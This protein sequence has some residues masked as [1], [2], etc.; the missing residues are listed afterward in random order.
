MRLSSWKCASIVACAVV[1]VGLAAFSTTFSIFYANQGARALREQTYVY[2]TW[3]LYFSSLN[4][5]GNAQYTTGEVSFEEEDCQDSPPLPAGSPVKHGAFVN[6]SLYWSTKQNVRVA[7]HKVIETSGACCRAR[8]L[9][10][11]RCWADRVRRFWEDGKPRVELASIHA[12]KRS[13]RKAGISPLTSLKNGELRLK[14]VNGE[15]GF[16]SDAVHSRFKWK[17]FEGPVVHTTAPMVLVRCV[18]SCKGYFRRFMEFLQRQDYKW[19][20]TRLDFISFKE[21]Y[22]KEQHQ[23]IDHDLILTQSSPSPTIEKRMERILCADPSAR[24]KLSILYVWMDSTSR[25]NFVNNFPMT[26]K[27]LREAAT[28]GVANTFGFPLFHTVGTGNTKRAFNAAFGGSRYLCNLGRPSRS[29]SGPSRACWDAFDLIWDRAKE[30]GYFTGMSNELCFTQEHRDLFKPSDRGPNLTMDEKYDALGDHVLGD[31][32]CGGCPD[33]QQFCDTESAVQH[34]QQYRD[35]DYHIKN[36]LSEERSCEGGRRPSSNFLSWLMK[37]MTMYPSKYPG[38]FIYEWAAAHLF[39]EHEHVCAAQKYF[40]S[41]LAAFLREAKTNGLLNRTM[42]VLAGDHGNWNM[43]ENQNPFL[44]I[45]VPQWYLDAHP[46]AEKNLERNQR[47]LVTHLDV[48]ETML[49]AMGNQKVRQSLPKAGGPAF[50]GWLKG[51]TGYPGKSLWGPIG[52]NRSCTDAGIDPTFPCFMRPKPSAPLLP[53]EFH[54]WFEAKLG[55]ALEAFL[56]GMVKKFQPA[57]RTFTFDSVVEAKARDSP[58]NRNFPNG[59]DRAFEYTVKFHVRPFSPNA[60]KRFFGASVYSNIRPS[61]ATKAERKEGEANVRFR[62]ENVDQFTRW[63]PNKVCMP[64]GI[65]RNI[66]TFCQCR[67]DSEPN[68][69]HT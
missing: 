18:A 67:D 25:R 51:M 55:S 62:V 16:Y 11:P 61:K 58:V 37:V 57:C 42:V 7:D 30:A 47:N 53:R 56:L 54:P 6:P 29:P 28:D 27:A 68:A 31:A 22:A 50:E 65:P 8:D 45:T 24:R 14:C 32:F 5:G 44:S 3:S 66:Q 4:T 43:E 15:N 38:F 1:L 9:I 36:F 19:T 60:G 35:G 34:Q 17:R 63:A 49:D 2:P 59:W 23:C 52:L 21:R 40:D 46:L 13:F 20:G 33:G 39:R 10:W 48:H 26:E 12:D 69:V 64:P 41:S